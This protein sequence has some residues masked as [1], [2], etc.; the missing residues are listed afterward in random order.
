MC[1]IIILDVPLA[2]S[3]E[4]LACPAVTCAPGR[5]PQGNTGN[6]KA[7]RIIER[8]ESLVRHSSCQTVALGE[9]GSATAGVSSIENTSV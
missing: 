5:R 3:I 8:P 7:V 1:F 9:G 2:K 6:I 4:A